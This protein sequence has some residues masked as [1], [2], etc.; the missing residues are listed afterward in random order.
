[1]QK[2]QSMQRSPFFRFVP[3]MVLALLL[4][5]A[6]IG[7]ASTIGTTDAKVVRGESGSSAVPRSTL[8]ESVSGEPGDVLEVGIGAGVT[9]PNEP[10]FYGITAIG[11]REIGN[12]PCL[13]QLFGGL[14]DPAFGPDERLLGEGRLARCGGSLFIDFKSASFSNRNNR[15]VRGVGVCTKQGG[16]P[17]ER[18]LKGLEIHPVEVKATGE[19]IQRARTDR[20]ER[21]HCRIWDDPSLCDAGDIMVGVEMHFI[22]EQF[23]GIRSLCKSVKGMPTPVGFPLRDRT[24]F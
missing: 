2:T 15:F 20:F 12:R 5:T 17:A 8:D 16:R 7:Y 21:R 18:E 1:M 6:S 19:V 23:T 4:P 11:I 24:G 13:V 10:Q 22:D 9:L 3:T 14:L